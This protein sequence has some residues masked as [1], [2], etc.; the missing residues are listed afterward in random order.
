MNVYTNEAAT[1]LLSLFTRYVT[2]YATETPGNNFT[3]LTIKGAGHM[4]P[5]FKPVPALK[6]LQTFM[7]GEPF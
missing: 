4:V 6:M 1:F 5:E 7:A 3:F 2:N